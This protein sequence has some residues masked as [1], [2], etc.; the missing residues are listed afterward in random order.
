MITPVLWLPRRRESAGTHT[1]RDTALVTHLWNVAGHYYVNEQKACKLCV[2]MSVKEQGF[3]KESVK[4]HKQDEWR[5]TSKA[6]SSN[7]L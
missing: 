5:G 3:G 6:W 2:Y 1:Q 4:T 7:P